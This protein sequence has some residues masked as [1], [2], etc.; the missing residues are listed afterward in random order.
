LWFTVTGALFWYM[1]KI[2]YPQ[3]DHGFLQGIYP[4]CK[5]AVHLG[6][7]VFLIIDFSGIFKMKEAAA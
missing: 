6:L 7:N 5:R 2:T 3:M 1:L 4:V